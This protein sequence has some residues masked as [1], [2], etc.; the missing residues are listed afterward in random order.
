MIQGLVGFRERK[1]FDSC[2]NRYFWCKSHKVLSILA[3]QIRNGRE[4]AFTP[5]QL[6]RKRWNVGHVD[7]TT[8]NDSALAQCFKRLRYE[9]AYGR[10]NDDA[11]Q[12]GWRQAFRAAGPANPQ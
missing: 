9:R 3:G 1:R 10:E 2:S 5:Q 11:V 7:S 8:N 4:L 12:Q 6:I